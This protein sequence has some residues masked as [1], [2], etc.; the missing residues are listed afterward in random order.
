LNKGRKLAALTVGTALLALWV[1]WNNHQE[2]MDRPG[3]TQTNTKVKNPLAPEGKS[4]GHR[5]A[6]ALLKNH[7][8]EI[9]LRLMGNE[10]KRNRFSRPD[11]YP[12]IRGQITRGGEERKNT[13]DLIFYHDYPVGELLRAKEEAEKLALRL[14]QSILNAETANEK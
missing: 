14:D 13:H 6:E 7:V 12:M 11:P 3:L 10:S 8:G 5:H 2:E 4:F 9:T 1:N